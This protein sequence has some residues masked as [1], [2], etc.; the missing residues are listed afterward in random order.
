M[1]TTSRTLTDLACAVLACGST[2]IT[3]VPFGDAVGL[4]MLARIGLLVPSGHV[5]TVICDE[6]SDPHSATVVEAAGQLGCHCAEAGFVSAEMRDLSQYRLDL[7]AFAVRLADAIGVKGR[8]HGWPREAAVVWSLGVFD[9]FD[10]PIAVH[11]APN[12]ADLEIFNMVNAFLE[13]V[14]TR[15][16]ATAIL[17][18]DDRALGGLRLARG[19]RIVSLRQVVELGA[20]DT[21][22]VDQKALARSALPEALLKPTGRGRRPRQRELIIQ[23]LRE[24]DVVPDGTSDRE[25]AIRAA[26]EL[27]FPNVSPPAHATILR[28]I[29]D[30]SRDKRA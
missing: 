11:L 21:I 14:Q 1:A 24:M 16:S 28:A 15:T 29:E 2:T 18:N 22:T 13:G 7:A 27:R 10:Q 20:P 5:A 6:C 25:R 12:I 17:T 30:W 8:V 26:W 4:G 9:Y 3:G 23:I 19:A